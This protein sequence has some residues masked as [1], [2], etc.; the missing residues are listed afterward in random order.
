MFSQHVAISNKVDNQQKEAHVSGKQNAHV[1]MYTPP[2]GTE[3]PEL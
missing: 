1:L 3:A 2:Y